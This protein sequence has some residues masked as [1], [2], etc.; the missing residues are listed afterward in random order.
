MASLTP[1]LG[2]LMLDS[3]FP[4]IPGDIGNPDTWGFPV[5]Y[6][7]VGGAT[8]K[9]VILDD[10]NPLFEAFVDA[11]RDLIAKGCTG[12]S[13]TCGFL[14]PMRSKLAET[15]NVPV[16]ASALEQAAQIQML[17]PAPKTLGILTISRTGLTKDHLKAA[18]VPDACPVGGLDG[19]SFA[20]SILGNEPTLY[21]EAA[22]AEIA[23]AAVALQ[24]A[25]PT[26]G[27]ILLECTNMV[28]YAPSV[29]AATGLPVYSIYSYLNWFYEGLAPTEFQAA[30]NQPSQKA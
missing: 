30:R 23:Q 14:A 22:R 10:Q 24:A 13:T 19:S 15:L 25:N 16:A 18:R 1:L 2:I 3:R 12:L 27:A 6:A 20:R 28:P 9:A 7:V 5:R 11:G 29:R 17:L 8:P 26:L 21:V 4:R